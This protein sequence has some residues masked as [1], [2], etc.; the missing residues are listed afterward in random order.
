LPCL[1]SR[2]DI[3][4]G[5]HMSIQELFNGRL[6]TAAVVGVDSGAKARDHLTLVAGA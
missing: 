6:A 5:E 3:V 1:E 2:K 4:E